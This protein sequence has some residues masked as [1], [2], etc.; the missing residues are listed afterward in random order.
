MKTIFLFWVAALATGACGSTSE[1][2]ETAS[3]TTLTADKSS[4]ILAHQ[5]K[6]D[7]LLPLAAI[8][9]HYSGDLS[10]AKK[11]YN[12]RPTAKRHDMDTYEYTW[13][14]NRK[15]KMKMMGR[16]IE[17]DV[18]NRIGLTWVGND[19]FMI[20]RK[21]SPADNFRF[22][23]RNMSAQEKAEAFRKAGE[24]MEQQGYDK[25][26][27]ETAVNMGKDLSKE[28]IMFRAVDGVGDAAAW[29]IKE[30]SLIVLTGKITFQVIADISENDDT[31][32]ALAKKLAAEVMAT[33][34]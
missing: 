23:Y 16:E 11:N 28:D 13:P 4:C 12:V 15:R 3:T 20:A 5:T 1:A 33:C 22:Y 2:T 34:N 10:K 30:K 27:T 8:Q 6:L 14:G 32:I 17:Y 25:K 19:M 21:G 9:K 7:Q 18:S 24:R 26:Q 29:R 31:N